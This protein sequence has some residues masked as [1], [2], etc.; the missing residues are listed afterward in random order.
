MNTFPERLT[1][2]RELAQLNKSQLAA[3]VG[4]SKAAIGALENGGAKAPRPE[5]LFAIAK[6]LGCSA[7]WL[8]TGQGK[9]DQGEIQQQEVT[10]DEQE[11]LDMLRQMTPEEKNQFIAIGMTF[12]AADKNR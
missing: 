1:Y 7:K 11:M 9:I 6:V 12:I 4:I 8:A 10:P 3:K 5:N 2:A